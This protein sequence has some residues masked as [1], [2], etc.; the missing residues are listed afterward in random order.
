MS[1]TADYAI[2]DD[3]AAPPHVIRHPS[4]HEIRRR[5]T[6]NGH[7]EEKDPSPRRFIMYSRP[8]T[9]PALHQHLLSYPPPLL[10]PSRPYESDLSDSIAALSLHPTLEAALHILNAD[11][12]SAHPLV[13]HMQ[14]APAFEG[15]LLTGILHRIEGDYDNARAWYRDVRESDVF[16]FVWPKAEDASDLIDAVEQLKL[17]GAGERSWLEYQSRKEMESVMH[18]CERRFGINPLPDP[19]GAWLRPT[20]RI[21]RTADDMVAGNRGYRQ[22]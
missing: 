11:P 15:M 7:Q 9:Y 12:R 20:E 4:R 10:P 22:F 19:T 1:A 3:S 6:T 8:S 18:W 21:R 17:D 5:P 2:P 16:R 14:A 13:L